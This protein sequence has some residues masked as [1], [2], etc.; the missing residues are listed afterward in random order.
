MCVSGISRVDEILFL[1]VYM[2][3]SLIGSVDRYMEKIYIVDNI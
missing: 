2:K 3:D 1:G